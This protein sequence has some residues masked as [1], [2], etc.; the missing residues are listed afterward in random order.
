MRPSLQPQRCAHPRRTS[1]ARS[2]WGA[3]HGQ[4]RR[5]GRAA[6]GA[7]LLAASG[8]ALALAAAAAANASPWW[9]NYDLK[10]SFLCPGGRTLVLERN[11][12]QA[13][14]Q[15]G[16]FSSTLF[17]EADN[18]NDLTFRNDNFRLSLRGD[19]LTL[20]QFPQRITCLRSQEG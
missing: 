11:A 9:E 16:G 4:P 14:I 19:E 20:E 8:G 5:C 3:S 13:S 1:P 12:S 10:Q 15:G 7:A 2:S 6:A 18:S 17:R